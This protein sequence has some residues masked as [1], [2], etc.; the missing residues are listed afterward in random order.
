[1][2]TRLKNNKLSFSSFS[3]KR[4][5]S[6][7]QN[8]SLTSSKHFLHILIPRVSP[9]LLIRDKDLLHFPEIQKAKQDL[10]KR[11]FTEA[12]FNLKRAIEVLSSSLGP[13]NHRSVSHSIYESL[14]QLYL[15]D[16][17]FPEAEEVGLE[18]LNW[19]ENEGATKIMFENE[20]YRTLNQLILCYL[21]QQ[22]FDEVIGF[23]SL[24]VEKAKVSKHW[25][26]VA[27]GIVDMGIA[28]HLEA[29]NS[30]PTTLNP[31]SSNPSSS[32]SSSHPGSLHAIKCFQDSITILN[33]HSLS[34][35]IVHVYALNNLACTFHR[36]SKIEAAASFYETAST[37]AKEVEMDFSPLVNGVILT[38]WAEL[39]LSKKNLP[40]AEELLEE[41]TKLLQTQEP[42]VELIECLFQSAKLYETQGNGLFAE[43]LY[44]KT[45]NVI[46]T[47]GPSLKQLLSLGDSTFTLSNF[48]DSYISFLKNR[49]RLH[50]SKQIEIDRQQF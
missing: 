44:R 3:T 40:K 14:V 1:M 46:M 25:E 49:G 50:D 18:N 5:S 15:L 41:A 12:Q 30:D 23:S 35:S 29:F 8:S 10:E 22:K 11:K 13:Q 7:K 16:R 32:S 9:Q 20:I 2:L 34:K 39:E 21:N 43:G 4:N 33:S 45:R 19:F 36:D 24:L 48:F 31:P 42:S 28:Y 37:V 27:E 38:N 17:K 6:F 26:I 47:K